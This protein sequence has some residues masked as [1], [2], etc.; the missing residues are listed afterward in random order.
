MTNYFNSIEAYLKSLNINVSDL[1]TEKI[2]PYDFMDAFNFMREVAASG[3]PLYIIGDYD[4]DGLLSSE[5]LRLISLSF[6]IKTVIIRIPKRFSEGYG[7]NVSIINEIPDNVYMITVDN[8]ISA[9]EAIWKAKAKG[10]KTMVLDHHLPPKDSAMADVTYDCHCDGKAS[11]PEYCAAGMVYKFAEYIWGKENPFVKYLNVLAMV[12]TLADSVPLLGDNRNIV[13][14]GLYLYN[15]EGIQPLHIKTLMDNEGL[16][17]LDVEN[18]NFKIAPLINACGRMEDD[19]AQYVSEFLINQNPETIQAM[20][21]VIKQKNEE[22]KEKLTFYKQELE[23]QFQGIG[24]DP[25]HPVIIY[26]PEL[27]EG[28]LGLIA[29]WIAEKYDTVSFVVTSTENGE[30]KG[31]ARSNGSLH[32][33]KILEKNTALLLKSGGH[34]GAGGF[35][36]KKED[37]ASFRKA[38]L[39]ENV[40]SAQNRNIIQINQSDIPYWYQKKQMYAPFGMGMPEPEF[41]TIFTAKEVMGKYFETNGGVYEKNK[42]YKRNVRLYGD[43]AEAFGFSMIEPY[44]AINTPKTAKITGNIIL[45][46]FNGK[47]QIKFMFKEIEKTQFKRTQK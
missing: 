20:A 6:G 8:G 24:I 12:A 19:G 28:F 2:Y 39:Q 3:K 18:V 27:S 23:K 25:L 7:L 32:I 36:L 15:Q 33:K 43:G 41:Q 29:G 17:S 42:K 40:Y 35:S 47:D 9:N 45:N 46:R 37:Y 11:Y 16:A 10:I 22:R 4:V 1:L 5:E 34:E 14:R 38:L 26:Y 31:S 30:L 44:L 13:K 21:L